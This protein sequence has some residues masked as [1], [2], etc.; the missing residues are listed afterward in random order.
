MSMNHLIIDGHLDAALNALREERDQMLPIN[1][2]R[3]RETDIPKTTR[4][5]CTISFAEMK[6]CGIPLCMTT[7]LA[8][9]KPWIDPARTI[10]GLDCDFPAQDMAY[11]FA[12]GQLAY[13]RELQRR[14]DITLIEDRRALDA[15]WARW[16]AGDPDAPIGIILTME[17]ADPITEPDQLEHWV[18]LGLR[19]V[20]LAHYGHSHYA[21]GTPA[22]DRPD[23]HE[24]DGPLTDKGY[25][26]LKEMSRLNIPLDMT[27]LSDTSFWD[28]AK[29]FDGRVYSSHANCRALAD[30]PRQLT[31]DMI[32]FIIE[33]DGVLGLAAHFA[34]IKGGFTGDA[35]RCDPLDVTM[36]D[37]ANHIDH[38]CQIAG[39]ARHV[40]IGS[41]LD[42][43][44]GAERCPV[45]LD[46]CDDLHKLGP[47][48]ASRGYS[49]D[50]ITGFF[51][52]NWLRLL[53][54]TLPA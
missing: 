36:D 5:T 25:A 50:D 19:S 17:G 13:Y 45:G 38:I 23:S 54:E 22:I 44:F 29:A 12:M 28:A 52:G 27:H 43:G 42:G 20:F 18:D 14:G 8:R 9:A 26:L 1:A 11:A 10:A 48:M 7:V 47:I 46:S 49:D 51:H 24:Q 35:C 32:R 53:R 16:E 41:D 4:G 34:M 33:R 37:F 2:I 3:Q 39:S 15:F 21:C 30:D 6:R 31:D 40:A